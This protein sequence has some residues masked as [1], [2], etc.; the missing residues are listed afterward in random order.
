VIPITVPVPDVALAV[1][2][3]D[4]LLVKAALPLSVTA[5]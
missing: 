4:V 5:T 2:W 1:H 3:Y